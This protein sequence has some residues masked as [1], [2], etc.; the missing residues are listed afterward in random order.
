MI[1]YYIF[2]T[3]LTLFS[4]LK[5]QKSFENKGIPSSLIEHLAENGIDP[6]Q[7]AQSFNDLIE[8]SE[9]PININLIN[10]EFLDKLLFLSDFNIDQLLEYV[11]TYSPV[12]SKYQLQ[13][14]K[15]FTPELIETLSYFV[16][17]GEPL[18]SSD[19]N[20]IK[21]KMILRDIFDLENAKGYSLNDSSGYTGNKHHLFSKTLIEYGQHI[22]CGFTFDKDPGEKSFDSNNVPEFYSGFIEY[23]GNKFINKIIIG[24][25]HANFGQGLALYTGSSLGKSGDIFL[26]KKRV[27]GIKRYTS[28]NET[29]YFRGIASSLSWKTIDITTFFSSKNIDSN[30]SYDSISH[31]TIASSFPSTGYHRTLSEINKKNNLTQRTI[32]TNIAYRWRN[33]SVSLGSFYHQ[34]DVDSIKCSN[35]YKQ[36]NS[37]KNKHNNSW[38]SYNYGRSNFILFGEIATNSNGDLA[39]TNGLLLK[40]GSNI[41]TSFLFRKFSKSYYS[42]W[43][44]S[45]TESSNPN[46]ESGLYIGLNILPIK[47]LEIQSYV[48]IFKFNWLEYNIDKP[49]NGYEI[50]IRTFYKIT[51]NTLLLLQYRE[52]EKGKNISENVNI[53][54]NVGY[55]NLKKIRANIKFEANQNWGIQCRLEKS[56][57]N[58]Y[59]NNSCGTLLYTNLNYSLTNKKFSCSLRYGLFNVDD[60]N[61]RI[62]TYENDVLYNF[63]VPAFQDKGSR[64]YLLTKWKINSN[65]TL[66]FKVAQT[67][68]SNKKEIGSGLQTITSNTKTNFKI[69]LQIK[70]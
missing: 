68:Y 49:S 27:S 24:D 8:V 18:K 26:I 11:K 54:N 42:P 13:T 21:A 32:G 66:W 48:D 35:L 70:I 47:K 31:K 40:P 29:D 20:Y 7:N 57:Y 9:N 46:G 4:S 33:I 62:Y 69:Q 37:P 10:K 5:A 28:A 56:L 1:K 19:Q 6:E 44:N 16:T 63:S 64:T 3:A 15:D 22:S 55:Y 23:N 30:I 58:S 53:D 39:L 50:S 45:F 60:Y 36:L 43:M 34:K 67:W 17:F 14:I 2:I 25:F 65:I 38:I 52:K 61:S 59:N 12:Y 51:P 41:S